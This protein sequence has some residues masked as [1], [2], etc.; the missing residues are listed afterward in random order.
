MA[1]FVWT[2]EPSSQVMDRPSCSCWLPVQCSPADLV[3]GPVG[4]VVMCV[5]EA[6]ANAV[7]HSKSRRDIELELVL[8]VQSVKVAV[9][10]RGCGL[11]LEECDP[12]REP[13]LLRLRGR[14]LYLMAKLMDEFEISIDGGTEIR[15]LRRLTD[16]DGREGTSAE[17]RASSR[18]LGDDVT[19]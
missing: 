3:R 5:H 14:G 13:E 7:H 10:D 12:L 2:A 18:N 6:C 15:M 17:D 4:D 8:D 11:D 16:G 19:R 1:G 9:G